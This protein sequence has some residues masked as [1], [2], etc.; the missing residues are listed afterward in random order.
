MIKIRK[1]LRGNP[2]L[3]LGNS[4]SGRADNEYIPASERGST[5]RS[6]YGVIQS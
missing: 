1:C 4:F 3:E 2:V 5:Y 6:A